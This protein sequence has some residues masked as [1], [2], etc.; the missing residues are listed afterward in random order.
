MF[1]PSSNGL[2]AGLSYLPIQLRVIL[3]LPYINGSITTEIFN[4]FVAEEVLP[5]CTPY[6]DGGP[7]SI[8]ILDTTKIYMS[9]ELDDMCEAAGVLLARL[10]PY[11]CN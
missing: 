1:I 11:S 4:H 5:Q 6:A 3:P 8:I 9:Q 2:N 10:P 7:R